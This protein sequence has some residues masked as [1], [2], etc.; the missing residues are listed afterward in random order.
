M[1]G[2]GVNPLD[3]PIGTLHT[4]KAGIVSP[5]DW[6]EMWLRKEDTTAFSQIDPANR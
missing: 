1:I 3:T 4:L 6:K 2:G 5:Q